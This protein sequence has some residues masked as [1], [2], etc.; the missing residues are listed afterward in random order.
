MDIVDEAKEREEAERVEAK[1]QGRP[2]Q[3]RAIELDDASHELPREEQE[4]PSAEEEEGKHDPGAQAAG[5]TAGQPQDAFSSMKSGSS[6]SSNPIAG[7]NN[8]MP[9]GSSA[10]IAGLA[11]AGAM[12]AKHLGS[13]ANTSSLGAM[14][15]L[16]AAV[17]RHRQG[18][19]S[20]QSTG[21]QS[22]QV[23]RA[24]SA[25]ADI[26]GNLYEQSAPTG[27]TANAFARH[28]RT[29]RRGPVR[30]GR[31]PFPDNQARMAEI[32]RL[33]R[34]AYDEDEPLRQAGDGG[35]P[36]PPPGA[37]PGGAQ[38]G[39]DEGGPAPGPPAAPPHLRN[40][41]IQELFELLQLP[42]AAMQ[43]AYQYLQQADV[44]VER[45]A[46]VV[47]Q[48]LEGGADA[49][50]LMRGLGLPPDGAAFFANNTQANMPFRSVN[51]N[52][53]RVGGAAGNNAAPPNAPRGHV[54]VGEQALP[55]RIDPGPFD[56]APED[57]RRPLADDDG[58]D[59]RAGQ[60][61]A[62]N[63][64]DGGRGGPG[65]GEYADQAGDTAGQSA[66]FGRGGA[67][68]TYRRDG[69]KFVLSTEPQDGESMLRPEF[70]QAGT[71][72]LREP[73]GAAARAKERV[74]E[75]WNPA[76]PAPLNSYKNP[77]FAGNVFHDA[78]RY[79]QTFA[80]PYYGQGAFVNS[81]RSGT[82]DNFLGN[83]DFIPPVAPDRRDVLKAQYISH[84]HGMTDVH[85]PAAM[86]GDQTDL[87]MRQAEN[88]L[89][90][91]MNSV[92]RK[93]EDYARPSYQLGNAT[94]E[95]NLNRSLNDWIANP[96]F[97]EHAVN[98]REWPTASEEWNSADNFLHPA[99]RRRKNHL[100]EIASDLEWKY[101]KRAGV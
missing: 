8:S 95:W 52:N 17:A 80:L 91:Y 97:P 12:A 9:L 88:A 70:Y 84:I 73:P 51:I 15:A 28:D 96:N 5:P 74:A 44:P 31:G 33:M 92:V 1:Q 24:A 56:G 98:K 60:G 22:P 37:G 57:V 41:L 94:K 90:P 101:Y 2:Q 10:T 20:G 62:R 25:A 50:L 89:T 54:P 18:G 72:L 99:K 32:N 77:L 49:V 21:A 65:A 39:E 68:P 66:G 76:Y 59:G 83:K 40:A 93:D 87:L 19:Q 4:R 23:K 27:A 45:L 16:V 55:G 26:S 67:I 82:M 71:D 11:A 48:L 86:L 63:L 30:P 34:A 3:H 81:G 29:S 75:W 42:A 85:N 58:G 35:P 100:S 61:G 64:I 43:R 78:L 13:S 14:A 36:P 7:G 47:Q 46:L 53:Q 79:G 6:T 38:V 69:G